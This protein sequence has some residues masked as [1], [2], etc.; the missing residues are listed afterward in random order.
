MPP[1]HKIP[2]QLAY[3]TWKAFS[4]NSIHQ[5][6]VWINFLKNILNKKKSIL[7]HKMNKISLKLQSFD[8][9]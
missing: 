2:N 6:P 8:A 4:F 7:N 3:I 9:P 5:W 1:K